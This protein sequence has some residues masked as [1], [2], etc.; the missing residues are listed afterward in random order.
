M[1]RARKPARLV[2]HPADEEWFIHDGPRRLRTGCRESRGG[3]AAEEALRRYLASKPLQLPKNAPSDEVS[4]G[5]VLAVY[6]KSRAGEVASA[7][8]LA[9]CLERL[10]DFWGDL[11]PSDVDSTRCAAYTAHRAKG[12]ITRPSRG[13]RGARVV[14]AGSGTVRRELGVLQAALRHAK[15]ERLVREIFDVTLPPPPP[16]KERALTRQEAAWLIRA[17]APH[18]RR[19]IVLSLY[20]GRRAS[21]ILQLRWT[22][23]SAGGWIDTGRGEIDFRRAGR[24]ETRKQRGAI[25]APSRLI[26]HAR[27]WKSMGGVHVIE[28][29]DRSV[30]T[31]NTA[32]HAAC[33]RAEALAA[34]R[35]VALDFEDVTPHTLKHTSVC[36]FFERGGS[37]EDAAS[38]YATTPETLHRVYRKHSPA[39]QARAKSVW[40][41]R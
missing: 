16:P 12:F 3:P 22:R 41:R 8:T 14:T 9:S 39:Y 35:G 1:P 11:T 20:T 21:A 32:F 4:L 18:L 36:W 25:A 6:A 30:T 15:K 7:D 5:I 10:A 28:W 13:D 31:I 19:F 37:L 38:Y 24:S 23:S 34:A 17:A 27:R 2:W 33:R 26:A 40:D 29:R